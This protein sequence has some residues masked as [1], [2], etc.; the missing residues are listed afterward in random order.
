MSLT[1]EILKYLQTDD[2]SNYRLYEVAEF[3]LNTAK[4]LIRNNGGGEFTVPQVRSLTEP[5]K[6]YIA[7]CLSKGMAEREISRS[8]CREFQFQDR[9]VKTWIR[10]IRPIKQ[11]Q[12]A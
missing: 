1:D 2:L 8:L 12:P 3:D 11:N 5:I 9:K 7:D 6:R 4:S 10:E